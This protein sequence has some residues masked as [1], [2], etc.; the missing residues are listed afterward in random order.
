MI[1]KKTNTSPI[2]LYYHDDNKNDKII[3]DKINAIKRRK[4]EYKISSYLQENRNKMLPYSNTSINRIKRY[5]NKKKIFS[6]GSLKDLT[7]SNHNLINSDNFQNLKEKIDNLSREKNHK[8]MSFSIKKNYNLK[9]T[10]RNYSSTQ[11]SLDEI[12]KYLTDIKGKYDDLKS[13]SPNSERIIKSLNRRKSY[14]VSHLMNKYN[15]ICVD[16]KQSRRY[17]YSIKHNNSLISRLLNDE[18]NDFK[19]INIDKNEDQLLNKLYSYSSKTKYFNIYKENRNSNIVKITGKENEPINIKSNYM[20]YLNHTNN[21]F[22]KKKNM[23]RNNINKSNNNISYS[24]R[25]GRVNNQNYSK[26]PTKELFSLFEEKNNNK[27]IK[28]FK[29]GNKQYNSRFTFDTQDNDEEFFNSPNSGNKF[30]N[31]FVNKKKTLKQNS[32][33]NN[34]RNSMKEKNFYSYFNQNYSSSNKKSFIINRN[35]IMPV[36]EI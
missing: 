1:I 35:I 13:L 10:E 21:Q 3:D 7:N 11:L 20:S 26:F 36:N 28:E 16:K 6:I 5:K 30:I 33:N 24:F 9:K 32:F 31:N 25:N 23:I 4:K 12:S 15:N 17:S 2:Y 8:S 34:Y 19:S 27:F 18:D 29:K 22:E 14:D